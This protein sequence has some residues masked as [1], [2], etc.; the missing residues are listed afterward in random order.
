MVTFRW[1]LA[2]PMRELR[3]LQSEMNAILEGAFGGREPVF[4]A[5]NVWEDTDDL[6]VTCEVPGVEPGGID[7]S[8]MGDVLTISGERPAPEG[9]S[10]GEYHRRERRTG[11]FSRSV[12]L[13]ARVDPAKVNA[14]FADGVL[15]VTLGKAAEERPRRI[16]IKAS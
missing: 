15:K 9:V 5:C 2:D 6:L 3:Q 10:P 7:V 16:A 12:E 8:V 13:P 14:E 1:G 11:A 4:P